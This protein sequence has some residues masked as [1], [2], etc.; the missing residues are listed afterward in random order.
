MNNRFVTHTIYS[1]KQI[2]VNISQS[3]LNV[4]KYDYLIKKDLLLQ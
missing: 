4:I 3:R 2:K 1:N